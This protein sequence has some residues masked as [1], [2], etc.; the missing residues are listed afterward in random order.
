MGRCRLCRFGANDPRPPSSD[1]EPD[2]LI[3]ITCFDFLTR[4]LLPLELLSAWN[5]TK[6]EPV[7]SVMFLFVGE[8]LLVSCINRSAS[9]HL[10]PIFQPSEVN[11]GNKMG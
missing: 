3:T 6:L 4:S 7:R 9:S 1:S 11:N 5:L 10:I 2:K 8:R